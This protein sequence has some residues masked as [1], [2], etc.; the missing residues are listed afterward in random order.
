MVAAAPPPR[1]ACQPS[2]ASPLTDG[3]LNQEDPADCQSCTRDP[4]V[5]QKPSVP[6]MIGTERGVDGARYE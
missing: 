2:S 3:P 6:V 1:A 5:L 4:E